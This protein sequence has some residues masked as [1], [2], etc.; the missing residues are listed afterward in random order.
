MS[1]FRSQ[2]HRDDNNMVLESWMVQLLPGGCLKKHMNDITA[3]L[4][5]SEISK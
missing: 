5:L 1:C 4:D 3:N 2:E